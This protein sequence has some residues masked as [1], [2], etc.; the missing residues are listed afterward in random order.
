MKL[1]KKFLLIFFTFHLSLFTSQSQTVSSLYQPGV[2]SEG[3]VYFLPKTAVNVT[4]L[5]EK[6]SY[7]PD[8]I[9]LCSSFRS[10]HNFLRKALPE[11]PFFSLH[12]LPPPI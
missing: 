7:Q 8:L 12:S 9:Y 5:V 4:L 11:H 6:T 1:M 3:A 10:Q 2:T